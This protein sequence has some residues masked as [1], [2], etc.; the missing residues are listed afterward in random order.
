MYSLSPV[1]Q[2]YYKNDISYRR[3]VNV[4]NKRAFISAGYLI[5]DMIHYYVHHGSPNDGTYLYEMK[6]YHSNHHFINHDKGSDGQSTI[7]KIYIF[8]KTTIYNFN[9][10]LYPFYIF[11]F[12]FVHDLFF[13]FMIY[14]N[15][16]FIFYFTMVYRKKIHV[17]MFPRPLIKKKA[18]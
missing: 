18:L 6:R 17:F 1:Y 14:N 16:I 12:N 9:N 3:R 13:Y 2:V 11:Y 10:C 5:Y 8:F 7:I 15:F 4:C